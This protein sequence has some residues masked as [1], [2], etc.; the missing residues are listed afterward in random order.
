MPPTAPATGMTAAKAALRFWERRQEIAANNLANISTDGFKGER[1]FARIVDGGRAEAAAAT[2]LRPGPLKATGN[3]LD[4]ALAGDG[5]LVVQTPQGERLTRAGSLRLDAERRLVDQNGNPVLG[6]AGPIIVP[7]ETADLEIDRTGTVRAAVAPDRLGRYDGERPA[8][9][10]L[11]LE[12][13]PTD[14]ALGHAG[15][16]YFI[17]G[18]TRAALPPER[19]DLR[20]GF[21][22]E[23]NVSATDALVEMITIQRQFAL[24]QR[25]AS[26]LDDARRRAVNDLGK[27]V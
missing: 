4:I 19:R 27:P 18:A 15:D 25:A 9:G 17:P 2:D 10:Q 26:T 8:L 22:E 5:F 1:A 23:S 14:G 24:A 7:P 13:A 6:T 20:Q 12:A 21:L 11:R 3:P 16:R